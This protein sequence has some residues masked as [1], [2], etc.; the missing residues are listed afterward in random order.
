[1]QSTSSGFGTFFPQ[2]ELSASQNSSIVRLPKPVAEVPS[3]LP[4]ASPPL[5]LFKALPQHLRYSVCIRVVHSVHCHGVID[6]A[7]RH[8]WR[9]RDK[10]LAAPRVPTRS[11]CNQRVKLSLHLCSIPTQQLPAH[12]TGKIE[13]H[14]RPAD[15]CI[16]VLIDGIRTFHLE[17]H[18]MRTIAPS[19]RK[20]QRNYPRLA[21]ARDFR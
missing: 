8:R 4:C 9:P 18:H 17:T 7:I 5:T 11:I 19:R 10:D 13:K 2:Y 1:M 21:L 16:R 3:R 12:S 14:V 15:Q 6:R 20:S